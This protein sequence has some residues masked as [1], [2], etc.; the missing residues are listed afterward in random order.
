MITSDT[1]SKLR[2]LYVID[3]CKTCFIWKSIIHKYNIKVPIIKRIRV[4]D[5]TRYHD[6]GILGDA[7][8]RYLMIALKED[9]INYPVLLFDGRKIQGGSTREEVEAFLKTLLYK[10]MIIKEDAKYM[11]NKNCTYQDTPLKNHKVICE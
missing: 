1:L 3:K 4:V 7:S 2:I 6:Y 9:Y 10:D 11:F 5:C 8:I